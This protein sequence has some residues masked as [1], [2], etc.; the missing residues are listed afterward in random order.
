MSKVEIVGAKDLLQ[1]ALMLLREMGIFQI[2][3]AKVGFV[4]EGRE[5]DIRSFMPDEK[6]LEE[7]FFLEDL[8]QKIDEL[9]S[10]LP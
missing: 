1:D 6:V 2:E 10:C 4:E 3:P 8:R 5:H 7:R 9:F